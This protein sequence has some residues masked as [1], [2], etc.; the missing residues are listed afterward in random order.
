MFVSSQTLLSTQN[1]QFISSLGNYSATLQFV[2]GST[3]TNVLSSAN[4]STVQY[5]STLTSTTQGTYNQFVNDLLSQTSSIALSSLYTVQNI[6]LTSTNFE[7]QI[8]PNAFTNFNINIVSP[9]V[10]GSSNYRIF[11]TSNLTAIPY[12]RGVITVNVSTVGASYSN[13][14]GQLCL[15]IYRWGLPT[16][17][18][19]SVYPSISNAD[20]MAMYEY[21]IQ[22]NIMYT[23]L[24]NVYPRL[25]LFGFGLAPS[26]TYN[27][28]SGTSVLPNYFWRGTPLQLRWNNYTHF[29]I[30][31]LGAPP[32]SPEIMIDVFLNGNL[33]ERR[34]P[35]DMSVSSLTY[36]LPYYPPTVGNPAT[37]RIRAY[38]AGKLAE[39]EEITVQTLV[40]KF[41]EVRM[42]PRA[43]NFVA[44]QEIQAWTD[45]GINAFAG[46]GQIG[47][48][49]S[50]VG[51]NLA[52]GGSNT[53]FGRLNAVDGNPSTI[54]LGPTSV[55]AP[56]INA[57]LQL[58]P[59]LTTTTS[60]ISS[61]RVFNIPADS[62]QA[63]G[64]LGDATLE[65]ESTILR[66]NVLIG[67]I[68]YYSSFRLTNAAEQIFSF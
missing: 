4:V 3:N 21:T 7:S 34:G 57:Y 55:G 36:N 54:V 9:L 67:A 56:D 17:V 12:R 31:M 24:L 18:W 11:P 15:D 33:Y 28:L 49:G 8:D 27:V 37:T 16:T 30:G 40:P 45:T 59:N 20:Y 23:N 46:T 38:I 44:V 6:T 1:T 50:A 61:I 68:Q 58:L 32:Y 64:G 13:N 35:F 51:S 48:F 62:N 47:L 26:Q 5:L 60:N 63:R 19:G 65:M 53:T 29:P 43:G 2:I 42:T 14:S 39:A 41:Q 25:R 52:L 10:A 22:S 66:A